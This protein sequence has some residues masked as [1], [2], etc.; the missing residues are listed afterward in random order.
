[1]EY[2]RAMFGTICKQPADDAYLPILMAFVV[3]FCFGTLWYMV[4][5]IYK[6]SGRLRQLLIWNTEMEMDLGSSSVSAP[7]VIERVPSAK[8]HPH[9]IKSVDIFR[10]LCIILMIFVNYGGGQY[11]FFKHSVWNGITIADLVFPWFLWVMGFSLSI[12]LQNK[13][14]RAVPRRHLLCQVLKRSLILVLLGLI[15]NSNKNMSTIADLRFPG[16]L[17]R[18]GICY[19]VVGLLEGFFTK[20]TELEVIHFDNISPV[21]DII[22]AWPQWLIV[23]VLVFIHTCVTF[24]AEVPGCGRGYLGPG[25]LDEG[26]KYQNCTGGVAGYIDREVFG[27]HM[28][29]HPA[30]ERVYENSVFYDPEGILGTLT[31]ILTVY[32]GVQ[33]GRTL[34][35][36]QSIRAK[37]IRWSVWGLSTG[38]IGGA[39]CGFSRDDGPVPLNKQLWSL[40][41]ALVTSGMAFII[42]GSL[43]LIVDILRKWGGR[44]FFYP[45]MNAIVLYVGHELMRDTFPFGWKPTSRTHAT[46]LFMNLW[47]T[48]LWVAIAIFL[49]KRNIFMTI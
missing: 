30:C 33:A 13:L 18:I 22:S 35:T 17:Q 29:R 39:L 42:Q 46:Y 9:R 19:L 25:G 43:F 48:F 2:H 36:Y 41:F 15:L 34:N 28:Y 32:F 27:N 14:R 16:V 44:P 47:G 11:W 6:N 3:L 1:M 20:R 31:S 40:S 45:G 21:Y 10:G 4:K 37:I 12:S 49:Y 8:K 23:S 24:L 38:L 5:C 7:L 26:G